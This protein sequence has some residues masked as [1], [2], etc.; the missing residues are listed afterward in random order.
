RRLPLVGWRGAGRGRGVSRTQAVRVKPRSASA[1]EGPAC[2]AG[3]SSRELHV[4]EI[5]RL[6]VDADT[7]RRDPAFE[8]AGLDHLAHQPLDEVAVV[9]RRQPLVLLPVPRRR[10]DQLPGRRRLDVLELADL[11]VE[12]HVR[13]L[14]S[15]AHADPVDDLVPAIETTL[16]V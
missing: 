3:A 8:L 7:R 16:A 12:R 10:I 11:A 2:A 13:Q 4:F 1:S 14:K 5:T 9:L 6:V 15:E